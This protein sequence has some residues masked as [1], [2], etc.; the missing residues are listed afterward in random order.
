MAMKQLKPT[1]PGTRFQLRPD[2]SHLHRGK[3]RFDRVGDI[4]DLNI[5]EFDIL[6]FS[7]FT[8]HPFVTHQHRFGNLFIARHGDSVQRL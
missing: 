1:S 3:P 6:F 2:R 4:D 8:D 5:V 7:G